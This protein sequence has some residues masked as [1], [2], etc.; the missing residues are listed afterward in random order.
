MDS[1]IAGYSNPC[2]QGWD[3][4]NP[5]I[6]ELQHNDHPFDYYYY[7]SLC[8]G[9]Q[10]CNNAHVVTVHLICQGSQ[11]TSNFIEIHY[12]C[13]TGE[14]YLIIFVKL[15]RYDKSAIIIQPISGIQHYKLYIC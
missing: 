13:I 2:E 15:I 6:E 10:S 12:E 14:C 11:Q 8:D 9:R 4:I 5:C 7:E 1:I 3:E